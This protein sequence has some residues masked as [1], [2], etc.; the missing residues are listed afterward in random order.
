MN[1][2]C[3]AKAE[4]DKA[5][6][7]CWLTLQSGR[8]VS[9]SLRRRRWLHNPDGPAVIYP[10]GAVE[11][12]VNNQLHRDGGQP[13]VKSATREIY[14]VRGK[15]HRIGG[16]ADI[17]R[18]RQRQ[19]YYV[20][21]RLHNPDG[22][23]VVDGRL[24]LQQYYLHGHLT[25]EVQ[26]DGTT[27]HFRQGKLHGSPS[28][29]TNDH[30]LEQHHDHGRLHR[31]QNL[32]A[33]VTP[34]EQQYWRFGRRSN[35]RGPAHVLNGRHV[36][37]YHDVL[38]NEEGFAVDN[39]FYLGGREIERAKFEQYWSIAKKHRLGV[40]QCVPDRAAAWRLLQRWLS[41]STPAS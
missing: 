24:G 14:F 16:P 12:W 11:Y 25:K 9:V 18:R 41:T 7:I 5:R 17:D 4:P 34:T 8:R 22:P 33:V 27:R 6:G 21:D 13:A 1:P 19:A 26:R 38:H 3:V 15:K 23:A 31:G 20:N 39:K 35:L 2:R 40:G 36:Y 30:S 29:Y 37:Y 10:S 32:P 28:V